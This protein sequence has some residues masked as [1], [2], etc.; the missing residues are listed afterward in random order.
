[1]KEQS[2]DKPIVR[3]YLGQAV[4]PTG[5]TLQEI[6]S[7]KDFDL[8]R[9]HNITQ[10]LFPLDRPS[11]HAIDA[12]YLSRE[13]VLLFR[14]N[15]ILR[16]NYIAAFNRYIVLF[17]MKNMGHTIVIEPDFNGNNMWL[18]PNSHA[19]VRITRMLRSMNLLGFE[20]EARSLM[21]ALMEVNS[22]HGNNLIDRATIE[23]WNSAFEAPAEKA[24]E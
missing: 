15:R 5:H 13:E 16:E 2:T 4:H 19:F 18:Y 8:N 7:N 22:K 14:T 11:H 3:F 6:L 9:A 12:P 17:A 10:W 24:T 20:K 1:V 21:D 23:F